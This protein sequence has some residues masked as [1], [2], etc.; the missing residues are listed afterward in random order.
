MIRSFSISCHNFLISVN[1]LTQEIPLDYNSV[2]CLPNAFA[3]FS[4]FSFSSHC[5]YS[6]YVLFMASLLALSTLSCVHLLP[7]K[8][9]LSLSMTLF[10]HSGFLCCPSLR[11]VYQQ[12]LQ[13]SHHRL[14]YFQYLSLPLL[15][16][17]IAT[18]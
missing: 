17:E 11:L 7:N 14:I 15:H 4:P 18:I 3:V 16:I 9:A 13:K 12:Y 8:W 2:T 10:K 6:A 1:L 5:F